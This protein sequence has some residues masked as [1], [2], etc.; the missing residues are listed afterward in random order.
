M[1]GL[2]LGEGQN[3]K[4][5]KMANYKTIKKV[6]SV[7]HIAELRVWALV[8]QGVF[9]TA[10]DMHGKVGIDTDLFDRWAENNKDTIEEWQKALESTQNGIR[11]MIKRELI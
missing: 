3:R 8:R 2:V 9:P 7:W 6:A 1:L 4:V 5:E 11:M 10:I